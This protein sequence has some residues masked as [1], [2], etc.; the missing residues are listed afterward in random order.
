MNQRLGYPSYGPVV[1]SL[2]YPYENPNQNVYITP[3]H[4]R[5]DG[6]GGLMWS[7]YAV[8]NAPSAGGNMPSSQVNH[9]TVDF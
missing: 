4:Q 9:Q 5:P 1:N 6:A 8:G 3:V 2:S 7:P